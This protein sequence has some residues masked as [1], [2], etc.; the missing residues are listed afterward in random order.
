MRTCL[1]VFSLIFFFEVLF[2]GSILDFLPSGYDY[3]IVIDGTRVLYENLKKLPLF[4]FFFGEKGLGFEGTISKILAQRISDPTLVLLPFSRRILVAGKGRFVL[5]DFLRF[6]VEY[7]INFLRKLDEKVLVVEFEGDFTRFLDAF[8]KVLGLSVQG[9]G[10]TFVLRDKGT[11]LV[12]KRFGRYLVM[13]SVDVNALEFGTQRSQR[14]N[15]LNTIELDGKG[16]VFG[17][18]KELEFMGSKG[19]AFLRG[20]V[21]ELFLEIVL[22]HK[23]MDG[24]WTTT[25]EDMTFLPFLGD[26]YVRIPGKNAKSFEV[27]LESWFTGNKEE[28]AKLK[29]IFK[30]IGTRTHGSVFVVGNLWGP[31]SLSVFFRGVRIKDLESDLVKYGAVKRR[32]EEMELYL[33]ETSFK[34]YEY[35]NFLVF[36]SVEKDVLA[37]TFERRI[38]GDHPSY[39]FFLN[40]FSSKGDGICVF[41][42]IGRI[43]GKLV[44]LRVN[45]SFFLIQYL[46]LGAGKIT[47][48]MGV[49]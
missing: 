37:R 45:A 1:I 38:L 16:K 36:S 28:M 11:S 21:K 24:T 31:P 41:I 39:Q 14:E 33:S 15:M 13:S 29:E 40:K 47:Y 19:E 12:L 20:E 4:E 44:G 27:F 35:R 48:R 17:Y 2:F 49:M 10:D 43:I 18:F 26:L 22:E 3:F 32:D 46:D 23:V 6:D 9:R 34:I 8:S 30:L 7:F 5:T 25:G 42:D